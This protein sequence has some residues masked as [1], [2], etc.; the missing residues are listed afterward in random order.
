MT[1]KNLI[2]S[3]LWAVLAASVL[4]TGCATAQASAPF[5]ATN[6][7]SYSEIPDNGYDADGPSNYMEAM[8]GGEMSAIAMH[9]DDKVLFDFTTED[10]MGR[11]MIVND[12]VMGGLSESELFL[13]D[14]GTV[15]FQGVLSLENYGGF[16]SIRTLPSRFGLDGYEGLI[17]RVRGDGRRYKL[18][19]STDSYLDGPAYEAEFATTADTW[20]NVNITFAETEPTFRGRR[21]NNYPVLAGDQIKKIGFML[22]DKQE[23]TFRLEV[24]WVRAFRTML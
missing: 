18:R 15:I 19:L 9:V 14:Q 21:M 2:R 22:A 4:L 12:D 7:D 23:G 5:E 1:K 17:V 6:A 11:W 3:Y 24:D 10:K 20:T 13:T 16:A 8:T